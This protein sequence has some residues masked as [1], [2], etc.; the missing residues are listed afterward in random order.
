MVVMLVMLVMLM[1]M[2]VLLLILIF[3]LLICTA[4]RV[5]DI[6][7]QSV[8]VFMFHFTIFVTSFVPLFLRRHAGDGRQHRRPR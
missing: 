2:L 4:C 6:A 7:V 8:S 5:R 3:V 1:M